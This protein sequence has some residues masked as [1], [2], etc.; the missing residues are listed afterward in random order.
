MSTNKAN[1]KAE[2]T[3][4]SFLRAGT[5]AIT[6]LGVAG[7]ARANEAKETLALFGGPKTVT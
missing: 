1:E 5:V 2:S 3:R 6:G 7:R 4:R